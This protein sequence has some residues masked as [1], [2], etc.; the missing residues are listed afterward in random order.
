MSQTATNGVPDS[1]LE[2]KIKTEGLT[3]DDV[4]LVPGHS[5][6]MPRET[7]PSSQLTRRIEL[8]VPIL[9]SR[10]PGRAGLGCCTKTCP[11]SS[12]RRRC[13]A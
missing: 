2:N 6:V 8:N 12:R 5:T 1:A 13:A 4:L 3:Y 10:L 11:L 7:D 9:S